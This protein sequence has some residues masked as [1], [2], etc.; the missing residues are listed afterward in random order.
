MQ[1]QDGYQIQ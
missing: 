1:E